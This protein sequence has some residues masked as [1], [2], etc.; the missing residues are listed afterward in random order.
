MSRSGM[1][2]SYRDFTLDVAVRTLGVTTTGTPLFPAAAPV[3][4]PEWRVAML[5]HRT[6]LTFLSEKARS[7]FL[8]APVLLAAREMAPVPVALF[9]GSRLD[10]DVS[11]GLAGECDFILELTEPVPPLRA[12]IAMS[13]IVAPKNDIELSL[14]QCVAQ[15]VA[16]SR[17]NEVAGRLGPVHG[18]VTMGEF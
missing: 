6:Q 3:V 1:V 10:V 11:H 17:F 13:V 14:G 18:C 12:F 16:A 7:E 5:R 8:V 9:S 15:M 2:A 4:V